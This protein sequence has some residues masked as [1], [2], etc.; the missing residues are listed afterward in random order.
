[1]PVLIDFDSSTGD[2]A[3]DRSQP[4]QGSITE[5]DETSST[6]GTVVR[7]P[8]RQSVARI[9]P[10]ATELYENGITFQRS[11]TSLRHE[12]APS[13]TAETGGRCQGEKE[14]HKRQVQLPEQDP[15]CS[16][17]SEDLSS[18]LEA[19]G[20]YARDRDSF[21]AIGRE[22]DF[23]PGGNITKCVNIVSQT[24]LNQ[25]LK[26]SKSKCDAL[27]GV[28]QSGNPPR[29]RRTKSCRRQKLSTMEAT[30][31]GGDPARLHKTVRPP[32]G[33]LSRE[34]TRRPSV[35][36]LL[37]K[38][39][40][41]RKPWN[42]TEGSRLDEVRQQVLG[43]V[44]RNY[45]HPMTT[46]TSNLENEPSQ[47][48]HHNPPDHHKTQ[49]EG[50]TQKT[51]SLATHHVET[52]HMVEQKQT[53][54][55]LSTVKHLN[56]FGGAVQNV[57]TKSREQKIGQNLR[58]PVFTR[59]TIIT[60]SDHKTSSLSQNLKV[61][62]DGGSQMKPKSPKV[63]Q[64]VDLAPT[65]V[66]PEISFRGCRV[67]QSPNMLPNLEREAGTE[68]TDVTSAVF[69]K[70][71][72]HN[73]APRE[74]ESSARST[75][76]HPLKSPPA[77]PQPTFTSV[78]KSIDHHGKR[79]KVSSVHPTIQLGTLPA[80]EIQ[81]RENRATASKDDTGAL[82]GQARCCQSSELH[83]AIYIPGSYPIH[84]VDEGIADLSAPNLNN[85][86]EENLTDLSLATVKTTAKGFVIFVMAAL[87]LYWHFCRPVLMVNSGYWVRSRNNKLTTRDAAVT[88]AALPGIIVLMAILIWAIR[89]VAVLNLYICELIR[90]ITDE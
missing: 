48:A 67:K 60:G 47:Y 18:K 13:R 24:L 45:L 34:L 7:T 33:H 46:S 73:R 59:T 81:E 14:P 90:V 53:M 11:E 37:S 85:E 86:M 61:K 9:S 72:G 74:P 80:R 51:T 55:R 76:E 17:A 40:K 69:Q 56:R 71:P 28:S 58:V 87:R 8:H 70:F 75:R 50:A 89:A 20:P 83:L 42:Q 79:N 15:T 57:S 68:T 31:K 6:Q 43:L 2:A 88:I 39:S 25:Q 35:V 52:M 26:E 29:V 41:D 22:G 66:Y 36:N 4:E 1:M 65:D 19:T 49:M 82:M 64:L 5:E 23:D 54:S 62:G 27:L 10:S 16:V 21:L 12:P 78:I 30:A 84:P 3:L 38:G 32:A 44:E 77:G 63:Y